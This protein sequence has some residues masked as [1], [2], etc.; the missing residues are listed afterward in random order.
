[1]VDPGWLE[2]GVG[3]QGVGGMK[4]APA[5]L[6]GGRRQGSGGEDIEPEFAV[7]PIFHNSRQ[8]HLSEA[9]ALLMHSELSKQIF[10]LAASVSVGARVGQQVN[11]PVC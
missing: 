10:N 1:M 5:D 11:Q 4:G 9:T 8:T 2:V 7:E 3:V 6:P